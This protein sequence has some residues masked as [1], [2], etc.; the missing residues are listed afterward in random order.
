MT[1][2][3]AE[4]RRSDARGVR[5]QRP[6]DVADVSGGVDQPDAAEPAV[7]AQHDVDIAPQRG[8]IVRSGR[9]VRSGQ[10]QRSRH[11][12]VD[13]ERGPLDVQDQPL[14]TPLDR[15]DILAGDGA[16]ELIALGVAEDLRVVELDVVDVV[17]G[18][19]EQPSV[20]GGIR[21]LWHASHPRHR[22]SSPGRDRRGRLQGRVG[23]AG[24]SSLP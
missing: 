7:I 17:E 11:A 9:L 12:E 5:A 8:S 4:L 16:V 6:C 19:G 15:A 3:D 1:E 13:H 22:S 18:A 24:D 21:K 14:P 23:Q 20:P 10:H 2:H